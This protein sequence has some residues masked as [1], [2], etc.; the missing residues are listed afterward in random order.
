MRPDSQDDVA[1]AE[2]RQAS[3]E[4]AA[5]IGDVGEPI[6]QVAL[7]FDYQ[8]D[9]VTDIQ[10]QGQ[11][12]RALRQAFEYYSALRQ[13]GLNVDIIPPG[14]SLDGY[15]MVVVPCLPI[16]PDVLVEQ[17]SAFNGQVLI[18]PRSGS[19]TADFS[20]PA[21]LAPGPLQ[22][23]IPV[24]VTRVESLRPGLSERVGTFA[25][26]Q[27][28]E[29]VQTALDAEWATDDG[30]GICYRSGNVRYLTTCPDA[31]LLRAIFERAASEARLSVQKLPE[32]V[33]IRRN[34]DLTFAFNYGAAMECIPIPDDAELLVGAP[35]MAVAGIMIW[36]TA[37]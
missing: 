18:G 3:A 10:P 17:L 7:V 37:D 14:R 33:R 19:K 13:L 35:E 26:G 30:H 23:L 15:A 16:I 29:H 4:I 21:D 31:E 36:R 12:F 20:I 24:K 8:S 6:K 32:A 2:V 28:L 34:G 9:W 1:V 11:G 25:I 5:L 27:W 22:Q